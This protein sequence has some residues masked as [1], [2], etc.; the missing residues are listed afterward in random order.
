MFV[1]R[2]TDRPKNRRSTRL[3]APETLEAR[4]LPAIVVPL[5]TTESTADA[6][7]IAQITPPAAPPLQVQAVQRRGLHALPSRFTIVFNQALDAARAN[8]PNN[9]LIVAEGPDLALGTDDDVAVPIR[10]VRYQPGSATVTLTTR[11]PVQLIGREYVVALD[12]NPASGLTAA[13]GQPLD[14]N[15]GPGTDVFQIVNVDN[16]IPPAAVTRVIRTPS[17]KHR[18]PPTGIVRNG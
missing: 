9:Y 1:F 17:G 18:T 3:A 12:G 7:T 4:D 5:D 8:N 10:P 15:N 11:R 13:N 16:F 2:P 14:G 6:V